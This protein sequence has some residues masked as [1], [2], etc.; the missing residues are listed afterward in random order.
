MR[1]SI[2]LFVLFALLNIPLMLFAQSGYK[3]KGH[4]VSAEDNEPMV[5]VSILE[6]GT[7]NGV[8][9]DIDGNYTL[10]IK[11]TA[12][13]TLLFSYIGMQSQAHAVSAKTGT[14]NVRLVSDAALIDEVVVVAYGTRKKGT[15]AGAVSTVKAEKMENVPTAGF[16]QSLQ[17]QTPG[18]TVI[19]NS[20]EPSKAAVFQFR[21]TNSINSGTSPLFILDGTPISSADFNT[22]SPGDIESISV[23]KDASSTSIYG[24][25][26]ANGVVVITSKRGL[27]IDKAKVTLRAQWGIS[28]LASNDK[29][30]VMNTPERIQFEKEIGLDTGQDYD[31][32]SRTNVN[33]LDEVFNDRAP[34]Q[35]YELSVNR[36]TDRLNYYVSG[37]FYD[38]EGIA[39]SSSFRRYNMRA[40]AEV[41]ASNWLK[42]GTNTMMAY[43]EISQAEEGEP[44]L[45]TPISG[46][47][48]M[49]PYWNPYNADGSLASENDGT[50]T[51][52]GQNPIEWMANNP[53]SYKK[54]KLL[55]TVFAEITPIQNL[56]IRGQ[57]G[58]DYSHSTAFMQSF[59]SYIINNN[60][61]KAG[62]SSSDI[63]SLS[64]TLTANY[65]W[66]LNDDH[67]FNFLLGQEG[68][69]YQSSGF[70]VSTQG[71]NNDR[72][73]NLL[74]GTRATSWPDSN[75]AYSYLSFFFR[76][77]YNY[78]DLY[79]AE[80][81]ARTDASSRFGADHRWG[82]FWSLGFM[83]NIKNEAFLKDIEWLTS[84]QVK[85]STGTSG[86]SEIPYYDHLA[87][88]SGDANYN[89]EAGIYPSQ[90]GNEELS[91]EQTW[92]NN[93]GVSFGLYNRVNVNVDFYHKKTTNMLMLVPQSYAITGVGNRWD[94]IG[95]MMNRGVEIAIDGDVIRT[96][97]FTWN[98]SAN[99]S[100]NKNKL[101]ELYNGV[102]EYVNST[103]G[104]KYVVGH[105]VREYFMNRYAGVN[106]ANGDALWYTA[107]GELTTEFREEDKVMTGKSFDSPWVGGFGT[108][109]MWK[110]LSLSAQFS[111]MAKRYVMNNDRFFEESNG[112]YSA[113]NQSKRLLYDRWKKPGDITDIPRYGVTAQLDDR[114]LEN[115][116]FLRL[117]N[118][119]LAY[120]FPQSLLKKT[121][122]FTSARVYLQGQNL[123]TW[124]GFTGLDPEVAT[125]VYRAQY[126]A[127]RQF[128]LGIDVSF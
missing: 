81:A 98:L 44:A 100:Y 57:F 71:Q 8:I 23:L 65:R 107:D 47:R 48:F 127:S 54:Y 35:S 97:D 126:P 96:K 88:V 30:V 7:T 75:S 24:A 121:N 29:W 28:Q 82:M 49:L 37:G 91:W 128:T 120:A 6:K 17:G 1:K 5:G 14:L 3:V 113:Y 63:L 94:N 117:K 124:T 80:V 89:D 101:L 125:N 123:L 31:L 111:W 66:A 11:G 64:E 95:A 53:V 72:L 42:V 77:E 90:S 32:L 119:T 73:T 70:Q 55:S 56:T 43:E 20:G 38:Q 39:Q 58:A 10:E 45:Y 36:A 92:A 78:K 115:S 84:A 13:A 102:E 26:A 122:F 116:S 106:P 15:I 41:K 22:I 34:L 33:W 93:V 21:G 18:L 79:Y 67:S 61:G 118:L 68:I 114:F 112:L 105:S 50:W 104:L 62:R 69:D 46:S 52:T 4:V 51:G 59:P 25:R 76:G 108:S 2:L 74:T 60:S 86:N 87:L 9:T 85:L 19:S 110:G 83:W 103:T 40:N 16:D 99:V 27:A 109:L 12:S